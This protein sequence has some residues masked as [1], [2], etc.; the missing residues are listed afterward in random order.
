M[1]SPPG[2]PDDPPEPAPGREGYSFADA[3]LPP[4]QPMS[5][6]PADEP[7]ELP[8][9]HELSL[10]EETRPAPRRRR[11]RPGGEEEV[12]TAGEE[13]GDRILRREEVRSPP[14]WWHLPAGLFVVGLILS[15]I[16]VGV[17]AADAGAS[18]GARMLGLLLVGLAVQVIAVIALLVVVGTVFGIDYGPLN[19]AVVKL[20]A[21]VAVVDG[22]T[23]LFFLANFP[24]GMIVAAFVGAGV[25]QLLF[26]LS[27]HEMLLSVVPMVA[28]AWVLNAAVVSVKFQKEQKKK[29][30][31]AAF[32]LPAD[33]TLTTV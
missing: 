11:K 30:N 23:L 2:R 1:S 25:F 3:D 7:P 13:P 33:G 29:D 9:D 18:V 8:T 17:Q 32:R 20:A 21:V 6:P 4:R 14:N 19:E 26:R 5:L 10:E 15:L 22:L 24:L 28:A 31:P 16:P 27:I 12:D